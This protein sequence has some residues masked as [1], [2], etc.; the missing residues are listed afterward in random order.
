MIAL[1]ALA[2]ALCAG[3]E[4]DNHHGV[5]S[6]SN[7]DTAAALKSF[8]KAARKD[9]SRSDYAFNLGTTKTLSGKDGEGDL[10]RAV[11]LSKTPEE[12]ARALY[13]RGTARLSKAVAS[14]PGQA[15]P[16]GAITDLRDALKLRPSWNEAA[17]NLDRALRLRS[18]TPPKQCPNPKNQKN[19]Q[20]QDKK[21]QKP[22]EGDDKQNEQKQQEQPRPQPQPGMD[23]RDAQRLLDG[24][25]AREA[26]QAREKSR[27]KKEDSDAP[28]W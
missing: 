18:V 11:A 6:W 17:R 3:P 9:T 26:Q 19:D 10:S 12:K 4:R 8:E 16:S 5:E 21:D 25:S 20:K 24:A 27:Q 13:N 28:D 1:V 14:P 22:K 7:K 15:D 2:T 23:P